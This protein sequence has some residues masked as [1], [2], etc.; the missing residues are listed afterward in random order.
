MTKHEI[1]DFGYRG[2]SLDEL[3]IFAVQ[4][5]MVVEGFKNLKLELPG[6]LASKAADVKVE[7]ADRLMMKAKSLLG[8]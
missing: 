8:I 5:D 1:T 4:L 7:L 2:A 3:V 6:W